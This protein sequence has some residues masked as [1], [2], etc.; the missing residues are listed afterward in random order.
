M[1][2]REPKIP[3]SSPPAR[4]SLR[5]TIGTVLAFA[6]SALSLEAGA[7]PVIPQAAGFG[8]ETPAG[9]GGVVY[10]VTNLNE[11]GAGSLKACVDASGP[12]VCVFE[13]SGVIR[14]KSNLV[15]R[16]SNITIAGQTAPS[17]GIMLLG[18]G[19]HVYGASD[20]LVQHLRVRPGDALDGPTP[21]NRDALIISHSTNKFRNIVIDHCSFSWSIDEMA[22]AYTNW[23]NVTLSNNIMAN[24]LH[25]SLHPKGKHGYGLLL[26]FD[27]RVSAV[28]NLLANN[29]RRNPLSKAT[30]VAF[31]NNVVYNAAEG[32]VQ[33][34]T[35]GATPYVMLHTYVGN[36]FLRGPNSGSAEPIEIRPA[37]APDGE[38]PIGS[39]VYLSDNVAPGVTSD[40][41]SIVGIYES[42]FHPFT[43][44]KEDL[45]KYRTNTPPMWPAS[46]TR[47]PASDDVV[48]NSVLKNVGA[49]PAD[50]DRVDRDIIEGVRN[51][52]G[53][54]INCVA[55]NGTA[56]CQLNAGGWPTLANNR[57]TLTL[58]ASPNDMTPSGYTN[59]ELWLQKMAAEV[60]GRTPTPPTSPKLSSQ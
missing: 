26:D 3:L 28:G 9:R 21:E 18:A 56:R 39:K 42:S 7:V 10:R 48:L 15:I 60:E 43:A 1:H 8:I 11:S 17:P 30:N 32:V 19:L 41:W 20:V 34:A 31:A 51:R 27:G 29:V 4:A 13:V 2:E 14:M 55:A 36:V 52:T 49:R 12:R 37:Q 40:P 50:R 57:R 24:P 45:L 47:L 33:L 54:V 46:L 25:D 5:A 58:P 23:D 38:V 53:R 16:N 6:A 44:T 22:S 35:D 59:L